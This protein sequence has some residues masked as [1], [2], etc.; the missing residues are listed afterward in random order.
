MEVIKYGVSIYYAGNSNMAVEFDDRETRQKFI[1]D[2]LQYSF[3][4]VDIGDKTIYIFTDK[5]CYFET[6]DIFK[7]EAK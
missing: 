2:L 3:V 4:Q 1:D 5:V 7:C 6:Y